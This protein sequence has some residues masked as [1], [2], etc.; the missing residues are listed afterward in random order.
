MEHVIDVTQSSF[1]Q[2]VIQRSYE[3]PVVVD[4]WAPWCGPCRMLGPVLE[5][6]ANEPNSGFVLAKLNTDQNQAIAGQYDIRG[7]PAVKAFRNGQVV[8]EFVGVQP[9]PNVRQFLQ[10]V[11]ASAPSN[12]QPKRSEAPDAS[13]LSPEER[14]SKA[15]KLLTSGQGCQAEPLLQ[16]FPSGPQQAQAQRLLGL[17]SFLCRASRGGEPLG[18][19]SAQSGAYGQAA[20]AMQ[21]KEPSEALYH[22][23]VA[24]NQETD[25]NKSKV[26]QVMD[27]IFA[28][29]GDADPVVAQ[30][31]S[32]VN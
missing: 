25:A 29:L 16:S 2:D 8:N 20:S 12:G 1:Q 23:L 11:K 14:L 31:R 13:T 28:L 19:S 30:Y 9:E 32:L 5:R 4:F 18:A 17:A 22:L 10:Q 27:G 6:L 24:F 15:R 3:I 26:R 21:R 7:I